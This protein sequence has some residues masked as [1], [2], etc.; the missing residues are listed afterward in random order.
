MKGRDVTMHCLVETISISGPSG[1]SSLH[2]VN[3]IKTSTEL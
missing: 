2:G 3:M 1:V